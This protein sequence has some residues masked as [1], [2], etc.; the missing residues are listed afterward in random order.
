MSDAPQAMPTPPIMPI[1]PII[2][3][4]QTNMG[5]M[6]ENGMP[7][8]S[9]L[10]PP[11]DMVDFDTPRQ[12]YCYR[13]KSSDF[14]LQDPIWI[15]AANNFMSNDPANTE[16]YVQRFSTPREF[17]YLASSFVSSLK[18]KM[19]FVAIKPPDTTGKILI[20]HV[21]DGR[22]QPSKIDVADTDSGFLYKEIW[23]VGVTPTFSTTMTIP[24]F[25]PL[26]STRANMQ[27]ISDFLITSGFYM[28]WF[29]KYMP[30]SIYPPSFTILIFSEWDI[31]TAVPILPNIK[32]YTDTMFIDTQSMEPVG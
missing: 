21:P 22:Y 15:Y 18:V 23:D 19:T 6:Q 13:V 27:H 10:N 5:V 16:Q 29:S 20:E 25:T 3:P 2:P 14:D 30:G 28:S 11:D 4:A 1:T 7:V 26:R 31:Q 8:V 32:R 12:E 9:L 24:N 17:K